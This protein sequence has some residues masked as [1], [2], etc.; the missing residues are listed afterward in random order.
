MYTGPVGS[1]NLPEQIHDY[2]VHVDSNDVFWLIQVNPGAL[3]V[4]FDAGSARLR[5]SGLNVFDDHD[6]ANSLTDGLGL[7]G[8][9]GF[10]L[11]PPVFPVRAT[12]SFDIEW[13]GIVDSAEI[14]N[15]SQRFMGSFLSTGAT[16][17]WSV[18]QAGFRFES[19]APNPTRNLLSVLGREQ[20]GI[21]FM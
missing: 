7:P 2:N 12:A 17:S 16:I 9:L 18:E 8:E 21:F 15:D 3:E 11:I 13:N 20:N 1:A 10:P 6:L 14:H 4:N 19:E 5:V